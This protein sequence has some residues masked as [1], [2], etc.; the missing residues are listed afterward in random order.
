MN[1]VMEQVLDRPGASAW[2][3]SEYTGFLIHAA[4]IDGAK[5]GPR[6]NLTMPGVAVTV[7]EQIES[8]TRIAGPGAAMLIRE[9]PDETIWSIV[10]GWPT[11]FEAKRARELG[12]QAETSFDEIVKAHIEDGEQ[13]SA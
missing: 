8:L 11:R 9:V 12:F 1:A 3:P 5:V 4:G 7:G 13:R 2:R 6:R 10:K